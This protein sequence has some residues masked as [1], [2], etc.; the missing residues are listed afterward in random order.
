MGRGSRCHLCVW[1]ASGGRR[2]W[3]SG[4]ATGRVLGVLVAECVAWLRATMTL[5]RIFW[6]TRWRGGMRSMSTA[7]RSERA[8]CRQRQTADAAGPVRHSSSSRPGRHRQAGRNPIWSTSPDRCTHR[9]GIRSERVL[10]DRLASARPALSRACQARSLPLFREFGETAHSS[11]AAGFVEG[12]VGRA[13]AH[14]A[15]GRGALLR[16]QLGYTG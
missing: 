3:L 4:R 1:R 7:S 15:C 12:L 16:R 13:P 14:F 6:L 5:D 2:H 11:G 8:R 9:D 10:R